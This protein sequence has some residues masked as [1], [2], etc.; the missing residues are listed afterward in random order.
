VGTRHLDLHAIN[1][2]LR[3]SSIAPQFLAGD[4]WQVVND[5]VTSRRQALEAR[6]VEVAEISRGRLL[7]H[8]PD[9]QLADGAA[10][11]ETHGF[12]DVYNEP[13][14][15][16]WVGYFEDPD[17][18]KSRRDYVVAWIPDALIALVTRG[19]D[20]NPEGCIAWL[21]DTEVVIRPVLDL[22]MHD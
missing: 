5:V 3:P 11:F 19:I 12:F 17:D 7:V 20:V 16:T 18:E 15:G 6:D 14:W 21:D 10:E 4:R 1:T 13:P 22:L 9:E 2:C 8:C